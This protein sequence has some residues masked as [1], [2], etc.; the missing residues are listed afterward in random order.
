MENKRILPRY[1]FVPFLFCTCF[2]ACIQEEEGIERND[3]YVRFFN[4]SGAD[5]RLY[6]IAAQL[7]LKN[8]TA[9]FVSSFITD[10]GYPLWGKA[11][12]FPEKENTVYAVPIRSTNPNSE[13][14]TIWFF[15]VKHDRTDYAIY[16]RNRVNKII[17]Q[18]GGDGIE[19]TWMF[20][21]FTRN[22]LLK[23]PASG[24][25]FLPLDSVATRSYSLPVEN[26]LC[27]THV[28]S[29][30]GN[31]ENYYDHGYTCWS[32]SSVSYF[33]SESG[34]IGGGGG[35]GGGGG[36]GGSNS[37]GSS[38]APNASG[39]FRN[40]S[41][42]LLNWRKVEK[43]LNKILEDC[44][45]EA[46]YNGL[47]EALKGKT[48]VIQ[49]NDS[50]DGSFGLQGGIMGIS[51]GKQV[52]S[53]Q[54]FHE[55]MH[56]YR[57]YQETKA[58]YNSSLLNGEIEA[59]YAQYLYTSRL[60]EYQGSKWEERD[61][62]D[63]RRREI[64]RLKELI[65]YKGNLRLGIT[66]EKLDFIILNKIIPVFHM[67]HYTSDKYIYDYNRVGTDNFNCIRN[68]TINCP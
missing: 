64:K 8:D 57:A 60:P 65:D 30:T 4:T 15:I 36:S 50:E 48:L 62:K 21:Y 38:A 16:N 63:P 32:T 28:V 58:S 24:L 12:L 31:G 3:K 1:W 46:L 47:K 17:A 44:M 14:E 55:M 20:D 54:L 43:M 56:A 45:G 13:I 42:T 66:N 40:S 23:E 10:Y 5:T 33:F 19:E 67:Y 39:I 22:V 53:N 29:W 7:K 59:W 61:K 11:F 34:D 25:A 51:L 18:I 41:M 26:E 52:E 49:F 37:I 9:D 6:S 35:G 27:C 68:L 2:H